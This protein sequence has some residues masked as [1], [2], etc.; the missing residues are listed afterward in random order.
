MA[1]PFS[2][3]IALFP[4]FH[5]ISLTRSLSQSCSS[6]L[7]L[8]LSLWLPAGDGC[9]H[10]SALKIQRITKDLVSTESFKALFSPSLRKH[11]LP[12]AAAAARRD[13]TAAPTAPG[14]SGP[15]LYSPLPSHP[16]G[17]LCGRLKY[18]LCDHN[19]WS[20]GKSIA[21]IIYGILGTFQR[22]QSINSSPI[23]RN[24]KTEVV[25]SILKSFK[26]SNYYSILLVGLGCDIARKRETPWFARSPGESESKRS[27]LQVW[28]MI[29]TVW[30]CCSSP[31]PH[32]LAPSE[33]A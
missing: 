27:D 31:N 18:R 13:A 28:G 26:I 10:L 8:S 16:S 25:N 32:D 9:P 20:W 12:P 7:S 3:A 4:V 29:T 2:L 6:S 11:V 15:V 1:F 21:F 23:G 14:S 17:R 19:L 33:H 5:S 22:V 24:T 30:H